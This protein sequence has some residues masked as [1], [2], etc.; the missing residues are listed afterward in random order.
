M[1]P[2]I[3]TDT[4]NQRQL[5][6][7]H[8]DIPGTREDLKS[9]TPS[10]SPLVITIDNVCRLKKKRPELHVAERGAGQWIVEVAA[11]DPNAPPPR[12]LSGCAAGLRWNSDIVAR[13]PVIALALPD[14]ALA[15]LLSVLPEVG[16]W[17]VP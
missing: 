6:S 15:T 8:R 17:A 3:W 9:Q 13:G 12:R 1:L 14:T 5:Q 16:G 2:L 11:A 4:G 7:G 10:I